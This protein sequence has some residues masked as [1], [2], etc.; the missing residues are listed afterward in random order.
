MAGFCLL[1]F[2]L[3]IWRY[4]QISSAAPTVSEENISFIGQVVKEPAVKD[5]YIKLTVIDVE[6]RLIA[7]KIL[8]MTWRYPEYRYGDRLRISGKLEAPSEDIDGFNYRDYLR[9]DGILAALTW[10]KI[11]ILDS[12]KGSPLMSFLFAFKN[13]FKESVRL[14][15][16]PPQVGILEALVFG[17]EGGITKEWQQKMN[18]TGTRH[19]VAVSGMNITIIASLVMN[20][21]LALGFW[22]R[23]AFYFSIC[24]L[25]LYILMI[26]APASATR[27]GVMAVILL[28]AQYL[29]RLSQATRA[30][31]FAASLMLFL[32]PLL[33]KSDVGFQLSFLAVLGIIYFQPVL[34]KWLRKVP[35]YKIFPVRATLSTTL[36]AQVFTMPVLLYNFGYVP[37]L[38]PLTN[39][40]IV[41]FLAPL[42]ILVFVFGISSM[43][44]WPLGYILSW[45]T[46]LALT[47]VV[48]IINFFSRF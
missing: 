48:S 37:L 7:G 26:G 25:V 22:R 31:I 30:V 47:Y 29:G 46:W 34:G 5:N 6:P 23:H 18:R 40:L 19:I 11:E 42:T 41:P 8:V 44:L 38:S 24:L 3:G 1:V 39:I 16:S 43:I 12:G 10:P 20:F 13:K 45:P 28:L 27:A 9:K 17:D 2:V 32:N 33:L 4:E 35:D 15:I 21:L 36:S 14:F